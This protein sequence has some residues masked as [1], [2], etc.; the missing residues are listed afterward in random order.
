MFGALLGALCPFDSLG[1]YKDRDP[2]SVLAEAFW[3]GK[4]GVV[5]MVLRMLIDVSDMGGDGGVA[6]MDAIDNLVGGVEIPEERS[7]PGVW[8]VDGLRYKGVGF[9]RPF[10]SVLRSFS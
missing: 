7:N 6:A 3:R 9:L 4:A 5:L 2:S 10:D 1:P 8:G